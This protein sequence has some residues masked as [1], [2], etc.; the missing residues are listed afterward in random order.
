MNLDWARQN[1]LSGDKTVEGVGKEGGGQ[2]ESVY[3]KGGRAR[4]G[5]RSVFRLLGAELST[6]EMQTI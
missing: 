2:G 3:V 1:D 6:T 4:G 5:S